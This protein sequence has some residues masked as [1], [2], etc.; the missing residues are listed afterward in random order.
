M[1]RR[2]ARSRSL[3]LS[4]IALMLVAPLVAGGGAEAQSTPVA[5]PS[6]CSLPGQNG[7][8]K[9]V[10]LL[11]FD[12]VHFTRDVPNVPSD[13]E[14]MP[15][16]LN[17]LN[18]NG[19]VMSNMHTPLIAHT[20]A[21]L[22]STIT[23]L[24]G[25][26]TGVPI[27]NSYRF[28][29]PDGTSNTG[30]S[31]AY[32]TS[33]IFS[34]GNPA[35]SDTSWNMLTAPRTNT[36]APWVPFTRAGCDVG[37]AG[38]ANTVLENIGIDIPTVFGADSPEAAEVKA[39][40]DKATADFVGIAVHCA[41]DSSVCSSQ[42]GGKPDLLPT[43]PGGYSGYNA[44]F[45][46]KSVNPQL[47]AS[48]ALTDLAGNP[49][50]DP[51]GNAGFPGFDG[52]SAAVSLAY[53]AAMQEH[54]VPVTYAYLADAHD[55]HPSGPAYGPG[56]AGYVEALKAYDA[57]FAAFF[58]RLTKDGITQA[59]TLFVV[60]ADENDH[61]A[62]SKPTPADCD[63][64]TTPCSYDQIGE[65]NVNVTGL[66][67]GIGA[68]T[69]F[70][71]HADSAP[72]F[73]VVGQPGP[74]DANLRALERAVLSQTVTNPFTGATETYANYLADPIEM[75]VLHMITAD[76]ARIPSF[77][78]FAKPDYFIVTGD[79]NCS[80]PCVQVQPGFAWNHG[81]VSPDI[82]DTWAGFV[83]PGVKKA[84]VDDKT[85]A[86]QTDIR[87]TVIALTGLRDDYIHDGRVL[88]EEVEDAAIPAGIALDRDAFT[89]LA[90]LYKQ[91]NA[92]ISD[93][94]MSS[95]RVATS[96]AATD[97][98][99]DVDFGRWEGALAAIGG[100]RDAL[101]AQINQLLTA[102]AFNGEAVSGDAS[103]ALIAQGMA[104]LTQ[105]HD[106]ES[107]PPAPPATATATAPAQ[108]TPAA[109]PVK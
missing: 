104:L 76:P 30:V 70:S 58:D 24:Y 12:N 72:N 22:L 15:H 16:L 45:G 29:N 1:K 101:C 40:P 50:Q 19:V 85:W 42:N 56:E 49:I 33:P 73:Y 88:V 4:L 87:P 78:L 61:F 71:V 20:S 37:S 31:F 77:T 103:S 38:L 74:S 75:K 54:G 82:N 102:A 84:G 5:A 55:K 83:G 95:L 100:Q 36:P 93:F 53:V 94:G 107:G 46:A 96:A 105:I 60:S 80:T 41:K 10:I 106:L 109:T 98:P 99:K 39:D 21:D 67:A 79:P 66:L 81:T 64:V 48:G 9:H 47:G 51:K 44:L 89:A 32:W 69:N 14:Q 13:L 57:A 68:P 28:F 34:P 23:G 8:I 26:R 59:N 27:G 18:E 90:T 25:D 65:A 7:A 43:E 3:T 108:A 17:F 6:S 62:G 63:G 91:L 2:N 86:D 97:S 11:H 92:P 35:P 52:M